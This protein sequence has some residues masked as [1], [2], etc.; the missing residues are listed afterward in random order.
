[1]AIAII[2]QIFMKV[3]AI[4]SKIFSENLAKIL[5]ILQK[6]YM[7]RFQG[8]SSPRLEKLSEIKAEINGKRNF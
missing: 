5:E 2:K 4:F 8:H 1:M 7:V 6:L 3:F